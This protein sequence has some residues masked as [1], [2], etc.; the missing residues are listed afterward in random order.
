MGNFENHLSHI[1]SLLSNSFCL[2]ISLYNRLTFWLVAGKFW[3]FLEHA[4]FVWLFKCIF[5]VV[6]SHAN[7]SFSPFLL[8]C[9]SFQTR[10]TF[11]LIAGKFQAFFKFP[12]YVWLLNFV[13]FSHHFCSWKFTLSHSRFLLFM[14][15]FLA[16]FNREW[17]N[18]FSAYIKKKH[19]YYSNY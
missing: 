7:Y 9:C 12:R 16:S 2:Q 19:N 8:V 3:A 4:R 17:R 1:L 18:L 11:W 14:P 5:V 6:L 15:F 10:L 13:F